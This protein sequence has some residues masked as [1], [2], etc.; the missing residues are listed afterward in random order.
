M[1]KS[2]LS[3]NIVLNKKN[4]PSILETII[5]FKLKKNI[6]D[7]RINFVRLTYDIEKY[8]SD[9]EIK[10]IDIIPYFKK[11]DY[12]SKKYDIRITFD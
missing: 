1:L 2:N 4:L 5:F 6:K 9:L 8:F 7:I 12:I 11:I 3:I 10:Y